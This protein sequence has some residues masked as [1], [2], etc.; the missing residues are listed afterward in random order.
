MTS[1]R[2]W[3]PETAIDRGACDVPLRAA[4]R[5]WSAKWFV[6][7]H[8]DITGDP[9]PGR[10]FALGNGSA[11]ELADGITLILDSDAADLVGR[12]MFG[13]P[14]DPDALTPADRAA[15]D[16]AA[17]ACLADLRG[18]IAQVFRLDA[19][20][21]WRAVAGQPTDD[22][23]RWTWRV[24]RDGEPLLRVAASETLIARRIIA[25]LVPVKPDNEIA[26]LAT[27]LAPQIVTISAL[28]GRS[29]LTTSELG[30]LE[31]GDVLVLDRNVDQPAEIAVDHTPRPLGCAIAE[32][33]GHL[34]L[35]IL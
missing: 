6:G 33:D 23:R 19:A 34:R 26:P 5:D 16:G 28:V 2:P 4:V 25:G 10:P 1:Y 24:E 35:T 29:R 20:Q 9:E 12:L 3:L 11:W 13:A 30:G 8:P 22:A 27:A 17:Q 15:I 32:A 7:R 21:A 14:D 18:R 31:I